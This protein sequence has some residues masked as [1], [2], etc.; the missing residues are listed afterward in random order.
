MTTPRSRYVTLLDREIHF[1]EWGDNGARPLIMWHGLART[2]RDF[3][4]LAAALAADYH[5]IVPDT[6]GRGLSQWSPQ[7]ER[8]YCYDFYTALAKALLDELGFDAV[9]WVGTSMGGATAIRA[10]A[11]PLKDRI[12]RL[13]VNDIGPEVASAAVERIRSY[14]GKP[15]RFDTVSELEAYFRTI[16]EP[17]GYQT[18]A[19]WRRMAE[20][21]MRRLPDG[22]IT[23]HYD[24]NMVM[25]FTHHPE[26]NSQWAQW[27][28]LTCEVLCLRGA[29]SD[30][31]TKEIAAKMQT[32]GPRCRLVEVPGCGHAPCLNVPEQIELVREF[33]RQEL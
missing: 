22:G 13:V 3:D 15:P 11:G 23:T 29:E 26:D 4:D 6:I 20:T 21:S 17:Y 8:E 30:L 18:D 19:Q 5:I 16:Y 31:L 10:G 28:A 24:P 9:D 2:G 32:R 12:K 14:A 7:P 27:D 1:M 33:L 25:Q